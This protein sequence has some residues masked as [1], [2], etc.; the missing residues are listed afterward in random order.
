MCLT[1]EHSNRLLKNIVKMKS[2]LPIRYSDSANKG[3]CE[4]LIPC[5]CRRK[6]NVD[7]LFKCA[8]GEVVRMQLCGTFNN[9][10]GRCDKDLNLLSQRLYNWDL[11]R[12][13]SNWIARLG[14]VDNKWDWVKL[15][16]V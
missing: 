2:R 10:D 6:A 9:E 7:E 8:T 11:S 16:K 3:Y 1:K 12:V 13:K 14:E 5:E 15:Y 4:A